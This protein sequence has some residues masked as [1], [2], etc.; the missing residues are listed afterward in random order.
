[1]T[2]KHEPADTYH[3]YAYQESAE[4]PSTAL[5]K[6]VRSLLL[7]CT[8]YMSDDVDHINVSDNVVLENTI[9]DLFLY[10]F[11]CS[12][13]LYC[14]DSKFDFSFYSLSM[15]S[16]VSLLAFWLPFLNKLELF[17][18]VIVVSHVLRFVW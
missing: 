2:S 9:I 15:Y 5:W 17:S 3:L 6:R 16:A 8:V 14:I 4:P 11:V 1:M 18:S 13:V 10:V 7:V 12:T